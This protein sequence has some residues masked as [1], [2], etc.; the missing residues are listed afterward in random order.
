MKSQKR[1]S[2][3]RRQAP[4]DTVSLSSVA[5]SSLLALPIAIALGLL[6]LLLATALLLTTKD[7][8]RYHT[9]AGLAALYLAALLGG[10]IATRCHRRQAPLLC[11]LGLTLLFSLLL[12][13]VSLI[14]PDAGHAY[15]GA[16]RV[17]LYALLFPAAEVGALLGAR[18]KKRQA[19]RN[20]HKKA[21]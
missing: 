16:L 15:T 3:G 13:L 6:L 10:M 5:R 12:L 21:R 8:D 18:E 2:R 9:A 1:R 7:P 17:G 11:G 19:H 14:L 4:P 20:G